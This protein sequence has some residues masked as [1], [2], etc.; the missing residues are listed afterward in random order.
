MGDRFELS[1]D[2]R[3]AILN[4]KSTINGKEREVR[5]P[6]QRPPRVEHFTNR[7][8]ELAQLLAELQPGR[9]ATLCGPGGMGKSALAAEAVWRLAPGDAP[10]ARFPDGI[11]YYSFYN[12]PQAALA[13]EHIA[14]SWGEETGRGSPRDAALRALARRRALLL[15][16]GTEE[17][18]DLA[19]VLAVRGGCGVLVTSRKVIYEAIKLP[20]AEQVRNRLAQLDEPH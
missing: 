8:A 2:F 19:A 7:E 20:A 3:G 6:W 13:L 12:Q 1:G 10:P 18:D 5:I 17:S 4:I 16:D 14:R 15:L 11:V 9:V